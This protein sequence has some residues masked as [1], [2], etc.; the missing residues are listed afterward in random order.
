[1]SSFY[2]IS[3]NQKPFVFDRIYGNY[4]SALA[5]ASAENGDGV[6]P[7]RYILI[8]YDSPFSDNV[9]KNIYQRIDKDKQG[10]DVK[11]QEFLSLKIIQ[12]IE[13]EKIIEEKNEN[14]I[15]IA[16]Y[17]ELLIET[18]ENNNIITK[19]IARQN[20][21]DENNLDNFNKIT[22]FKITGQEKETIG[23]YIKQ[24]NIIIPDG[25]ENNYDKNRWVDENYSPISDRKNY[26]STVWMKKADNSNNISPKLEDF[27]VNV[28]ELN[29]PSIS[30]KDIDFGYEIEKGKT[31]KDLVYTGDTI[32][33]NEITFSS[34]STDGQLTQPLNI[35]IQSIGHIMDTAYN[36]LYGNDRNDIEYNT[37]NYNTD[38]KSMLGSINYLNRMLDEV[39]NRDY[40]GLGDNNGYLRVEKND[41]KLHHVNVLREEKEKNKTIIATFSVNNFSIG[42]TTNNV[43]KVNATSENIQTDSLGHIIDITSSSTTNLID[44][45][46]GA[47]PKNKNGSTTSIQNIWGNIGYTNST[48]NTLWGKVSSIDSIIGSSTATDS[49][50]L[51]DNIH[52]INNIIGSSN[53]TTDTGT[54]W[55]NIHNITTNII[56]SSSDSTNTTTVWSN[57]ERIDNIIGSTNT[58]NTLWGDIGSTNTKDTLW[59]NVKQIWTGIGAVPSST[60]ITTIWGNI[61]TTDSTV[62][63]LW[64]KV[65]SI[66]SIVGS[67][68]TTNTA[69]TN[70]WGNIN[71]INN[72]NTAST[73]ISE[74]QYIPIYFFTKSGDTPIYNSWTPTDSTTY[75][76]TNLK[77]ILNLSEPSESTVNV[78]QWVNKFEI[79]AP[80]DGT[81]PT[82]VKQFTDYIINYND[83]IVKVNR[84][85][86][87]KYKSYDNGILECD[88]TIENIV[89]N[90]TNQQ[91]SE[92]YFGNFQSPS[93]NVDLMYIPYRNSGVDITYIYPFNKNKYKLIDGTLGNQYKFI[94]PPIISAWVTGKQKS[95]NEQDSFHITN[96][97]T[98]SFSGYWTTNKK[99]KI[100]NG[101]NGATNSYY[102]GTE[103]GA[104]ALVIRAGLCAENASSTSAKEQYFDKNDN[105]I[106]DNDFAKL[107]FHA[108]GRWKAEGTS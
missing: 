86:S 11:K 21:T 49:S 67:S 66:D 45:S 38:T 13:K 105:Y 18:T 36:L 96:I 99:E 77:T 22:I 107:S 87:I 19:I 7:G 14:D 94:E 28:A 91:N 79:K 82:T 27:Y 16:K 30:L 71:R 57:I 34:L 85:Y 33:L 51:W 101:T 52:N 43:L 72:F 100:L 39:N 9:L 60:S 10:Q 83:K 103:I 81:S 74:P 90:F 78:K 5:A 44:L 53:T 92:P 76:I 41:G 12:E 47:I 31:L 104:N 97:S 20:S 50:T 26:D 42:K 37:D 61:G 98:D 65:S 108:V 4:T 3:P 32:P 70:L 102:F 8:E 63:T 93:D 1:M 84:N 55:D 48:D 17:K 106:G 25:I 6:Y 24:S 56:G 40:P 95:L 59:W 75:S 58:K 68:I 80:K 88:G 62:N 2:G 89:I 64:G 54:L 69:T 46:I 23:I 15:I 73:T 29:S 35:H